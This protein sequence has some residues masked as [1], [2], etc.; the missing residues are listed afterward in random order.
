M[1]KLRSKVRVI[2]SK[3][4]GVKKDTNAK[5]EEKKKELSTLKKDKKAVATVIKDY[6]KL[7]EQKQKLEDLAR[8]KKRIS[9]MS[10]GK[11]VDELRKV[12]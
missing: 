5:P 1:K 9:L 11:K 4:R 6:Q 10:G 12:K 3:I 8:E 7:D 2:D